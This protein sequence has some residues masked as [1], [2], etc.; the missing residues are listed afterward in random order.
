MLMSATIMADGRSSRHLYICTFVCKK[1][2]LFLFPFFIPQSEFQETGLARALPGI[3]E[4]DQSWANQ[5]FVARVILSSW[6]CRLLS[7]PLPLP[8]PLSFLEA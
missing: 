8:L 7:L 3:L 5:G 1:Q 2:A 6:S 4:D